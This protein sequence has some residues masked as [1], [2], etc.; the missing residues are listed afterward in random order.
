[1]SDTTITLPEWA[2]TYADA[3]GRTQYRVIGPNGTFLVTR[4]DRFAPFEVWLSTSL[5]TIARDRD[6]QSALGH[7]RYYAHAGH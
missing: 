6:L 1:M 5:N 2:E 3:L 7:A 4:K